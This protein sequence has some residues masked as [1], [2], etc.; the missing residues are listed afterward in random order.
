MKFFADFKKFITKGNIVDLAVAVV[1]GGAFGKIVNSLVNDI[2]MPLITLVVGGVSVKDWKW[3]IK[4]E[5]INNG[6]L[7]SA[8]SALHYGN[9]LQTIF[10]FLII[11]FFIFLALRILMNAKNNLEK[12]SENVKANN[13]LE[14]EFK[15]SLKTQKLSKQEMSVRLAEY[16]A[17][18]ALEAEKEEKARKA[19]AEAN[20]PE[21]QEKILSDIRELLLQNR[22]Q[23][24]KNTTEE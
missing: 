13:K 16:K 21:T 1:V 22:E 18:K 7:V 15:K 23:S 2:I 5:V 10:D 8:E 20:K 11:A 3:V 19:E 17:V 6:V 14:K 24:P 12:L 4:P 9:F